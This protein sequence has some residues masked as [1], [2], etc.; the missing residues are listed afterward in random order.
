M[1][2]LKIQMWIIDDVK[3][4]ELNAKIHSEEQ[5]AKIAESI[6]RFGWD[7]PIVVDKNGVIIKGHGRRLAAIKLGLIEVP[8]LVRDDLNE[9]Q[10]K[11]ARLA[12]NR[13]AIGDIDAD[14]L[15]LELQSINIEFLEEIFDSK[16]LEFMQADLSEMNVDVIVMIWTAR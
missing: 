2:E 12:D 13:V 14:L 15:K 10:V 4:Y 9:E 3:P 11:A 1:S 8:V 16:E 6:A 7:Q 5:V